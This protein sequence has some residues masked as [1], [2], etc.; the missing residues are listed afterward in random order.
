M[1]TNQF[2]NQH[3]IVFAP[4]ERAVE[5]L[6]DY[7]TRAGI[8]GGHFVAIG[9]FRELEL[10]YFNMQTKQYEQR[11]V[12]QQVEVVSLVGNVALLDGKP[13]I[14]AHLVVGTQAYQALDGHLGEGVVEPTLEVFLTQLDGAIVR[15]KD[16]RTGL[17]A[18]HPEPQAVAGKA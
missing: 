9:G 1:R 13:Y 12:K 15:E 8:K 4:G 18:L 17:D 3:V 11:P 7:C 5:G 10:K 6:V 16:P 14:H 2:G